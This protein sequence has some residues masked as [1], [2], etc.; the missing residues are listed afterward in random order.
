MSTTEDPIDEPRR[1]RGSSKLLAEWGHRE[2][3]SSAHADW[4]TILRAGGVTLAAPRL[5]VSGTAM[6]GLCRP[7]RVSGAV[8]A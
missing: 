3:V 2:A 7:A 4:M 8:H 6:S 1:M 5:V